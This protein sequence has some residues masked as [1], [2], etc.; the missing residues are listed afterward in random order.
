M[1]SFVAEVAINGRPVGERLDGRNQSVAGVLEV[2]SSVRASQAVDSNY[3]HVLYT[4]LE[5]MRHLMS[6]EQAVSRPGVV[7]SGGGEGGASDFSRDDTEMELRHTDLKRSRGATRVTTD[8]WGVKE[9][10]DSGKS[11]LSYS[12]Y[13]FLKCTGVVLSDEMGTQKV[14]HCDND[15]YMC[16]WDVDALDGGTVMRGLDSGVYQLDWGGSHKKGYAENTIVC[17]AEWGC[18]H[19]VYDDS[20]SG[21]SYDS[22]NEGVCQDRT[23]ILDKVVDYYVLDLREKLQGSYE[24]VCDWI[25]RVSSIVSDRDKCV[26]DYLSEEL[27]NSGRT[28]DAMAIRR[29]RQTLRLFSVSDVNGFHV[30]SPQDGLHSVHRAVYCDHKGV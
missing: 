26:S 12:D 28:V 5:G 10:I 29:R 23:T 16:F 30:L 18:R 8:R 11:M 7:V 4:M 20:E 9:Y 17:G 14:A 27:R 22:G 6:G 13:V 21:R 19:T 3:G 25:L 15:L 24:V 2:D 1:G